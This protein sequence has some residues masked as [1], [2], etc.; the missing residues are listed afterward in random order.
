MFKDLPAYITVCAHDPE[1][2]Q[3]GG[4]WWY[5]DPAAVSTHFL[6]MEGKNKQSIRKLGLPPGASPEKIGTYVTTPIF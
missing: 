6:L 3:A 2:A 1:L 4:G 5:Q